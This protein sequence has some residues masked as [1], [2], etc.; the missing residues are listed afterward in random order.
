MTGVFYNASRY[1]VA[2]NGFQT[3]PG[4]LGSAQVIAGAP[5]LYLPDKTAVLQIKNFRL[6]S[7]I[8]IKFHQKLQ[9][10]TK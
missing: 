7:H 3:V 2:T 9:H 4:L 1:S 5:Q 8:L 6:K 10:L